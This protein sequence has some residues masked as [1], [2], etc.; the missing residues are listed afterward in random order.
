V[1]PSIEKMENMSETQL[2]H[3]KGLSIEHEHGKIEW[4]NEVDVRGLNLDE[5][6]KFEPRSVEVYSQ[7]HPKPKRGTQL[8]QP[9]IITLFNVWPGKTRRPDLKKLKEYEEVL[10]KD[11]GD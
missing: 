10:K 8:N 2:A 5:I 1:T 3:L 4:E 7:D 6:I 9:A 11:T